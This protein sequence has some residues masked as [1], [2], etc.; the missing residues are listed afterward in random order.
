MGNP[1]ACLGHHFASS[2]RSGM[3]VLDRP[4]P[5]FR[6]GDPNRRPGS[7]LASLGSSTQG[8]LNRSEPRRAIWYP[9]VTTAATG[10]GRR[11]RRGR[12]R[13]RRRPWIPRIATMTRRAGPRRSA[14]GGRRVGAEPGRDREESGTRSRRSRNHS[15]HSSRPLTPSSRLLLHRLPPHSG[16][17]YPLALA[18]RAP[19]RLATEI[20][21]PAVPKFHLAV[22]RIQAVATAERLPA[23]A[24]RLSAAP[25]R[26]AAAQAGRQ[27][28]R[29]PRE[30]P[31]PARPDPS[32]ADRPVP[33][34]PTAHSP[35]CRWECRPLAL[36]A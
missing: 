11:A 17:A 7:R 10:G 27:A 13:T 25:A 36:H 18:A 9:P 12:G 34:Q 30:E 19:P 21:Y 3:S 24:P 4:Q 14:R 6:E 1:R 2:M 8:L 16:R 35:G 26:S 15:A 28:A 5:Q 22:R 20:G 33:R 31:G 29:L 32:V 23:R